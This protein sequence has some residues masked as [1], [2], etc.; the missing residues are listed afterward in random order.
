[1]TETIDLDA[2]FHSP[3]YIHHSDGSGTVLVSKVHTGDNYYNWSFAMHMTLNAKKN[4]G[5]IDGSLPRPTIDSSMFNQWDRAND[6][7]ASWLLNVVSEDI[8]DRINNGVSAHDDWFELRE[9]FSQSQTSRI[10]EL[11]CCIATLQ[12]DNSSIL[13]YFSELKSYWDE[14]SSISAIPPCSC[15]ALNLRLLMNTNNG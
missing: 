9:R 7:A 10:F 6:M 4:L 5:F 15:G 14:F 12:H 13:T 1:M 2:Y 11:T 8:F 3:Y